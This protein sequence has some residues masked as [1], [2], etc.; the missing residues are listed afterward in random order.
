MHPDDGSMAGSIAG[1]VAASMRGS[2]VASLAGSMWGSAQASETSSLVGSRVQSVRH[3]PCP[4]PRGTLSRRNSTCTFSTNVGIANILNERGIKA[5]TPSCVATPAAMWSPT[6]TPCNSPLLG[7]PMS[8]PPSTPPE[9]ASH[10]IPPLQSLINSGA[11]MLRRT[12]SP[13]PA[14]HTKRN[15]FG[16]TIADK[17]ERIGI[18]NLIGMGV[19]PLALPSSGSMY[20]RR[21]L[22]SPMQQLTCLK[23]AIQQGR[24]GTLSDVAEHAH[25]QTP[26]PV[27]PAM[28]VPS[29]PG[30]GAIKAHLN[31]TQRRPRPREDLGTVNTGRPI[32]MAANSSDKKSSQGFTTLGTL[33]T[34]LFGRKGGLL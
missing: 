18:N 17:V 21:G 24:V 19:T 7:S 1:S 33:S 6:A 12:F 8:T 14:G 15:R 4:T 13:L 9:Y 22:Q 29:Q 26:E 25:E 10:P 34:L 28:G 27:P 20:S 5:V 3:S 30:T 16:D 2:Q 11:E 31:R 23:Q 32:N